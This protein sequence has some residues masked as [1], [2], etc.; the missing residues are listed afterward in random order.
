VTLL[1]H[2][3]SRLSGR[4]NCDHRATTILFPQYPLGIRRPRHCASRSLRILHT[5]CGVT[6]STRPSVH[7]MRGLV[8]GFW[9][10]VDK[11]PFGLEHQLCHG[12]A[13]F[14]IGAPHHWRHCMHTGTFGMNQ[15]IFKAPTRGDED[16]TG[17]FECL[18]ASSRWGAR[19]CTRGQ[20]QAGTGGQNGGKEGCGVGEKER[21]ATK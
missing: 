12:Q 1:I 20:R 4:R 3:P 15:S 19:A 7:C 2:H 9:S 13:S 11:R 21:M 14:W 18:F 16:D 17:A 8:K 6:Y 10:L 5:L